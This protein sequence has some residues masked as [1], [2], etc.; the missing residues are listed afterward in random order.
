L[1]PMPR[2]RWRG[3]S[4]ELVASDTRVEALSLGRE[5]LA[6]AVDILRGSRRARR[7]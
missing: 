6:R 5:Q 1:N 7:D 3:T 2:R 4:A